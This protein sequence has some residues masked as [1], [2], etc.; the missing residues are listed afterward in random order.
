[1][2]AITARS[3]TAA[4]LLAATACAP[5]EG[6]AYQTGQREPISLRDD[7]DLCGQSLVQNF[8]GLRANE[9]LRGEI[10]ARS[11]AKSIRWIEP[12][13]PVTMDLRADRLNGELDQD[14]VIL[15]L[16]CG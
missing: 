10:A 7:D 16:R 12:G 6:P 14:G 8:L 1:M 11:E 2:T 13:M 15:S 9:A 3:L 5:N 4:L